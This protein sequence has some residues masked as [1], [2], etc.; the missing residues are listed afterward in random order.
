MANRFI[1]AEMEALVFDLGGVLLNLSFEKTY[2]AFSLLSQKFVEEIRVFANDEVFKSYECGKLTDDEFRDFLR[3]KLNIHTPSAALDNAWNA[4]LLDLP[5]TR[6]ATLARLKKQ[7]RVYLLSNTNSIHARHFSANVLESTG[8]R[9]EDYFHTIYYSH[10]LG[11]RKP[12]LRI[13]EHVLAKNNLNPGKVLFFDDLTAN[14]EAARQVGITT[15]HV[16]NADEL[17]EKLDTHE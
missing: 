14:I 16:T 15:F 4:M 13:Y 2:E 9:L 7:Y 8:K 3:D 10:A 6:L 12:D 17:F 11:L 5:V 1:G